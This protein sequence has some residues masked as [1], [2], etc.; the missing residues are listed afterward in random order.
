[1]WSFS[2]DPIEDLFSKDVLKDLSDA[3]R[4]MHP[5]RVERS[6]NLLYYFMLAK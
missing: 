1:M 5:S 6:D 2:F 4:D 3:D